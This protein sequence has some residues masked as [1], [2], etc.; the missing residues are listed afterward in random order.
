MM[1]GR[2]PNDRS[3]MKAHPR[4]GERCVACE[5]RG[6]ALCGALDPGDLCR[7]EQVAVDRHFDPLKS[8]VYEGDP[9]RHTFIL[10]SG[11]VRL[12]K[13]L[14]DG[15]R[16]VTG[17]LYPGHFLGL[18]DELR[19][20]YSAEAVTSATLCRIERDR[21]KELFVELP[22]LEHRMLA[23]ASREI[24]DTQ[25]QLLLLG[26]KTARERVASFLADTV[27]EARARGWTTGPLELPMSR[28]DISD[29][30]GLTIETVSRTLTRLAKDRVIA[31]PSAHRLEI[32][33]MARLLAI[34]EGNEASD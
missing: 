20:S 8:V 24:A 4:R 2:E 6:A 30:L 7:L 17:F 26:R 18:G 10:K 22:E 34:A 19:Y 29:Y 15:R 23:I 13:S 27:R 16:Q 21:L 9:A 31:L 33:D 12:T 1:S 14:P 5:V 25:K 3:A 11:I 28:A 32:P